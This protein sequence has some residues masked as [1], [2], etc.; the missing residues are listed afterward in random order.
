MN[1]N[2][3]RTVSDRNILISDLQKCHLSHWNNGIFKNDMLDVCRSIESALVYSMGIDDII[4]QNMNCEYGM[5]YF[6]SD[7]SKWP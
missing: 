6:A 1:K 5:Y 4:M 3:W 2:F 7:M